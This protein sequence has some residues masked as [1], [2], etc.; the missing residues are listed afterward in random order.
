MKNLADGINVFK[1]ELKQPTKKADAKKTDIV[2]E[3]PKTSKT[4]KSGAK[5]SVKK[6][7]KK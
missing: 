5:R 4:K 2:S 7:V 6:K 1:R 3:T